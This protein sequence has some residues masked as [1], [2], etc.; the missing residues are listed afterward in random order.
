MDVIRVTAG[1]IAGARVVV[2]GAAGSVATGLM[3]PHFTPGR[4]IPRPIAERERRA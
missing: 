3:M 2:G 1:E 4:L